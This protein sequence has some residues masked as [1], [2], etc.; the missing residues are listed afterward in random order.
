V[1]RWDLQSKMASSRALRYSF[2][3]ACV[4]IA[5]ELAR[6]FQHYRFREVAP[7]FNL[8]IALAT[9]YGGVG[10]SVLALLLSAACFD[11]FF[12]PPTYSF[13]ISR[14]DLPRLLSFS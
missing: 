14:G 1:A 6:T 5:M 11:Y 12:A 10:P 9:W 13:V 2:S 7:P 8:A 4:A 3:V